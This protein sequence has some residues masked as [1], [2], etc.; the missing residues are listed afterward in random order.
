MA[1]R[2]E[3]TGKAVMVGNNV[4]H[5]KNRNKR[6]FLPNIQKQS[7]F[8]EALGRDVRFKMAVASVRSVEIRGGL[9][10]FLLASKNDKLST[11]ARRVKKAIAKVVAAKA[12]EAA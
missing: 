4:S 11:K 1:R 12:A 10:N 7:L 8:S 9:D 6:R 5:A 2:C 3:L